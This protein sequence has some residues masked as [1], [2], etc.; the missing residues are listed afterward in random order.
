MIVF[1]SATWPLE[2]VSVAV[3]MMATQRT[4]TVEMTRQKTSDESAWRA[5]GPASASRR[6]G[7]EP[8]VLALGTYGLVKHRSSG[9]ARDPELDTLG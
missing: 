6:H 3:T 2:G 4:A 1:R 5:S 7:V 9:A 8:N